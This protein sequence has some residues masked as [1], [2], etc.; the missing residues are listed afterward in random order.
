MIELAAL[1]E[2]PRRAIDLPLEAV[3][4]LLIQCAA[5]QTALAAR[6]A[7]AQTAA[8]PAAESASM[9]GDRW[10]TAA[11]ADKIAHVGVRWLYRKWQSVGGARKFSPRKLRFNEPQ[12]R[13]W[14]AKRT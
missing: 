6:P 10:L 11:E 13:R 9:D 7:T 4:P 1:L 5:L 14:L 8:E 2:D 3:P 12:F